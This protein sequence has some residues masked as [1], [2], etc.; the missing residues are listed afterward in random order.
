MR[1]WCATVAMGALLALPLCA[2]QKDAS[3]ASNTN[4]TTGSTA[5]SQRSR[6]RFQ[7]RSSIVRAVCDAGSRGGEAGRYFFRLGQ[8]SVEPACLGSA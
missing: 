2:Q 6:E 5:T 3:T 7:Y 1:K 4:G 8:Q